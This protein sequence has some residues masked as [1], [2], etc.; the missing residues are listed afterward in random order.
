MYRFLVVL[1]KQM[2][3]LNG[4]IATA[5][6]KLTNLSASS[7]LQTLGDIVNLRGWTIKGGI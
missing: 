2:I 5:H 6:G 1:E 4:Q 3:Q 7:V